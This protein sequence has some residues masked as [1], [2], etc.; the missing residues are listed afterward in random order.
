[1]PTSL[2]EKVLE[3]AEQRQGIRYRMPP[4]P[5][6]ST[7]LDCSLFVVLTY[8]DAG[9]GLPGSARTAEQIRQ[10]CEP[11]D[12]ADLRAGDLL[13][14]ERTYN[15]T[16][17]RGPDGKIATHVG[18]AVDGSGRQMWD[19]HASD[20]N[21]DL[22]G[23]GITNINQYYWEPKLFD[24][25][26]APGLVGS[27]DPDEMSRIPL[28]DVTGPRFRVTTSGLRL[29]SAPGTRTRIVIADL[30]EG[31]IVTAVDSHVEERNDILWRHI[32]AAN[33]ME[34]WAAA[35][36]L[37]QI[38]GETDAPPPSTRYRVSTD[39]L[40]LRDQPRLQSSTLDTLLGGTIVTAVDDT[41][42]RADEIVWL[43]V[44]SESGTVGW[45]SSHYLER[46]PDGD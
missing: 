23:V 36:Y 7:S 31:S 39:A 14:F 4:D 11:I 27:E 9:V 2:R 8:R 18:I 12:R 10:A 16:G 17:Q 43:H 34:G 26:R 5:S 41:T 21:T 28:R 13:F 24:V 42:M 3:V 1:M 6:G 29:R 32:R 15:A 37:E 33:G 35:E 30:G 25:R 45:M 19:C 46:V 40:R 44:R 22:P 20:D 38:G